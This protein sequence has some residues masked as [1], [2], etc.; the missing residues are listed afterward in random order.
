[1]CSNQVL[2]LH[3]WNGVNF[4]I[5]F[6]AMSC[7]IDFHYKCSSVN[8]FF[9]FVFRTF[10]YLFMQLSFYFDTDYLTSLPFAVSLVSPRFWDNQHVWY[11][12]CLCKSIFVNI[13]YESL[14]ASKS[15]SSW[16]RPPWQLPEQHT[17]SVSLWSNQLMN[18]AALSL[19]I[20]FDVIIC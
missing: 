17:D 9:V 2:W 13:I 16:L 1:M 14:I 11:I 12:L 18:N 7:P 3:Y 20:L 5:Y 4:I 10:L 19:P 8:A 15:V 6:N